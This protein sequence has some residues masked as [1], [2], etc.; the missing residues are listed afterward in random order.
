M[1]IS[2]KAH[3]VLVNELVG[4]GKSY[5]TENELYFQVSEEELLYL[6]DV[7]DRYVEIYNDLFKKEQDGV[8]AD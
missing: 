5:P 3:K 2:E 1:H 7:F 8:S 4:E 6:P